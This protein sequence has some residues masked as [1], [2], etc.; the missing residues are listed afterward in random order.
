[1]VLDA[2]RLV[3]KDFAEQLKF[4]RLFRPGG[5]RDGLLV[6]WIPGRGSGHPGAPHL[7]LMLWQD[8]KGA[9]R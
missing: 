6:E 9:G 8:D 1:M 2:A 4:A 3:H 7:T 5:A